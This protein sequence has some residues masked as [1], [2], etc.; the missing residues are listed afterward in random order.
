MTGTVV[1]LVAVT[2]E[3]ER[4][5]IVVL[6]RVQ[7]WVVGV[8]MRRMFIMRLMWSELVEM[9]GEGVGET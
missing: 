3:E 5:G 6:E 8:G 4:E 2:K 7:E 9:E 1:G